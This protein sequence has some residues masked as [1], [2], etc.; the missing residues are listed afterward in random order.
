MN[1]L[2]IPT[3]AALAGLGL[4]AG[5]A[6]ALESTVDRPGYYYDQG[7]YVPAFP[8]TTPPERLE[9]GA[10]ERGIPERERALLPEMDEPRTDRALADHDGDGMI[11]YFYDE[12]RYVPA[13]PE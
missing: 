9:R 3:L 4:A 10:V 11:D 7:V 5:G 2:M 12:G 8:R 6:Q 13:F 1:R